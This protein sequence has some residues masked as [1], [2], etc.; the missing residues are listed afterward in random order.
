MKRFHF[1]CGNISSDEIEEAHA[2]LRT[3]LDSISI[4]DFVSIVDRPGNILA[5]EILMETDISVLV[6]G[7]N[8]VISEMAEDLVNMRSTYINM[9]VPNKS[10]GREAAV[11][12]RAE[13]E[14]YLCGRAQ[15]V[16]ILGSAEFCDRVKL[17]VDTL[18]QTRY[19]YAKQIISQR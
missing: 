5:L 19:D 18:N 7:L 10:S 3:V 8:N 2:F 6:C 4:Y 1:T 15:A 12:T 16:V 9:S 13:L 14:N 11:S 17:Y